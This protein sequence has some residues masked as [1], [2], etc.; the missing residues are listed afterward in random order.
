MCID[1]KWSTVISLAV[2]SLQNVKIH[3]HHPLKTGYAYR[4]HRNVI[5]IFFIKLEFKHFNPSTP[6]I[7]IINYPLQIY[8]AL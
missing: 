2:P 5:L 4:T 6:S 8:R 1:K 3:P 7:F